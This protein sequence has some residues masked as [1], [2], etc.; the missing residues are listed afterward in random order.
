[1][2]LGS[3]KGTGQ[4]AIVLASAMLA[5]AAFDD[6]TTDADT[7]FLLEWLALAGCGL[8]LLTVSWRLL[9]G[10]RRTLGMVS[11]FLIVATAAVQAA[12]PSEARR[13]I[14]VQYVLTFTSL[15][16]FFVLAGLVFF[17]RAIPHPIAR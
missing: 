15:L 17:R 13:Q 12:M 11:I 16:W 14:N 2:A 3:S 5:F 9:R 7:S 6:I 8:V 10:G 1:M 4:A